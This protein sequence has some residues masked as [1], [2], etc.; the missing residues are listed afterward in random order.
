MFMNKIDV[1]IDAYDSYSCAGDTTQLME[2]IYNQ[3]VKITQN[4]TYIPN[5]SVALGA[6]NEGEFFEHLTRCV[7]G[8]LKRADVQDFHKTVLIVGSSVGGMK[9]SEQI[10]FRDKSYA[11][12]D[13]AEHDI[14]T[15]TTFLDKA[16]SFAS[17]KAL[18]TA[19]TSSANAL[20][21]AKR[22]I[23]IG[24]YDSVLV[25]GADALCYTTVCGF[26]ALGVLSTKPS[27]PFSKDREGMNVAEAV[28][29]LHVTSQKNRDA[30]ALLGAGA[31]SD[32]FHITQPDPEA[33]GAMAAMDAALKDAD[34][35]LEKVDYINAHGTGT[36]ANDATEALATQELFGANTPISSTKAITGHTLGA[37]GALEAVISCEVI[38]QGRI[39]AQ[40]SLG[41]VENEH[42]LIPKENITKEV[43]Y[44]LSNSF[45]FGGNNTA[46]LFGA[47]HAN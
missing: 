26:D 6:F 29:V 37:A 27:T 13:V 42:I 3:E 43:H 30:I 34:V 40:S 2:S 20:L 46:L 1:Y 22:Y 7:K 11:N 18:S 31:S 24:A 25:V 9:K 47:C 12:I 39:P 38:K 41:E 19:C 4:S 23:E 28:A 32:A 17:T 15:I 33:K 21:L 35:A 45:A 8:V 5:K 10:Y 36:Q 16:F 44:V 14:S